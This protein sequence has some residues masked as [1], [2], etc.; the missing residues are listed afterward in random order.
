MWFADSGCLLLIEV[1]SNRVL[2]WVEGQGASAYREPSNHAR[3]GAPA[4]QPVTASARPRW[5]HPV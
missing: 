3:R 2:L 1:P 5:S 4:M